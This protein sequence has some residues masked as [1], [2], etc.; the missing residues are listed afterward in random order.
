[1]ETGGFLVQTNTPQ[2]LTT[3]SKRLDHPFK[4][5]AEL[6][7]NSFDSVRYSQA[8]SLDTHAKLSLS[9]NRRCWFV[10]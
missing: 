7:D 1:M 10:R 6:I 4:A 9:T 2:Y 8:L 3:I 5:H